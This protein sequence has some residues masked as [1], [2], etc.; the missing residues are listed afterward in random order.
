MFGWDQEKEALKTE[1]DEQKA[2]LVSVS[3][4]NTW[5]KSSCTLNKR[6]FMQKSLSIIIPLKKHTVWMNVYLIRGFLGLTGKQRHNLPIIQIRFYVKHSY[7]F[8][9]WHFALLIYL[10]ANQATCWTRRGQVSSC[11]W[12]PNE[13]LTIP[14]T[15]HCQVLE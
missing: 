14:T 4:T 9:S 6:L 12:R 13:E 1:I 3:N 10:S 2:G 8:F 15:L 11:I 7:Q 5:R